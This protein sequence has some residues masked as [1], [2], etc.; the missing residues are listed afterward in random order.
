MDFP[1]LTPEE[2]AEAMTLPEAPPKKTRKKKE[3]VLE[4]TVTAWFKLE[5]DRGDCQNP[6]CIDPREIK[7]SG[8]TMLYV[9]PDGVAICRYC[10]LGG[11][12]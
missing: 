2:I 9:M 5:H 4:R 1:E 3:V 10:Y 6:D 12:E 7:Y 8:L 11:Y